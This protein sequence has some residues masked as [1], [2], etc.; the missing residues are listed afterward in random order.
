LFWTKL[1][2]TCEEPWCSVDAVVLNC[3]LFCTPTCIAA[4]FTTANLWNQ[5]RY[6]TNDEWIKKMCYV[7]TMEYC[8]AIKKNEMM[9]FPGRWME[10]EI[11]L[12]EPC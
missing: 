6:P 7:Y 11:T 8:L 9:S 3:L 2:L 5:P 1:F 10:L 4:L 12:S